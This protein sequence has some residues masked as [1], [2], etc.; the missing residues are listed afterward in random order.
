M[1]ND[2]QH[3][4]EFVRGST[5]RF[6][7]KINEQEILAPLVPSVKSCLEHKNSYVRKYALLVLLHIFRTHFHLVPDAGAL[8]CK[9]LEKE[10]DPVCRKNAFSALT[11]I[12][13]DKARMFFAAWKDDLLSFDANLQLALLDFIRKDAK[14]SHGEK[15]KHVK[16]VLALFDAKSSA[17]RFNAVDVLCA[18][19]TSASAIKLSIVCLA[20]LATKEADLNVKLVVLDKIHEISENC[21]SACADSAL[22][23]LKILACSEIEIK[24]KALVL[25][26]SFVSNKHLDDVVSFL[27]KDFVKIIRG[28]AADSDMLNSY[29][30][31]LLD[32]LNFCLKN[33]A[34]FLTKIFPIFIGVLANEAAEGVTFSNEVIL[35]TV[36]ILRDVL[37]K[38]TSLKGEIFK[39]II[40]SLSKLPYDAFKECIWILGEFSVTADEIQKSFSVIKSLIGEVPLIPAEQ[41]YLESLSQDPAIE[42]DLAVAA[43]I[44]PK[45]ASDGSYANEPN[46]VSV[47]Q[48]SS[49]K[50]K[51]PLIREFL[52]DGKFCIAAAISNLLIKFYLRS[53][54]VLSS[55]EIAK[56]KGEYAL[57]M[58]SMARFGLS[59]LCPQKIDTESYNRILFD[60][61][62]ICQNKA[63]ENVRN[64]LLN[65]D[66]KP[67][68][69]CSISSIANMKKVAKKTTSDRQSVDSAINF[70]LF[71]SLSDQKSAVIDPSEIKDEREVSV[72]NAIKDSK[73]SSSDLRSNL[74]KVTQ[75]TGYS[76]PVYAEA[77]VNFSQYDI[78]MDVLLVNQTNETIQNLTFELTTVGDLKLNSK[79]P[80][81]NLAPYGFQSL[82]VSL[83]I[84]STDN[85]VIH[86]NIVYDQKGKSDCGII[87]LSDVRIDVV[88]Y[89]Q[90][91]HCSMDEFRKMYLKFEWENKISI[92]AFAPDI[93]TFMEFLL[94]KSK[95]ACLTPLDKVK[96]ENSFFSACLYSKTV[97]GEDVVANISLEI[98]PKKAITGHLRLRS[99][100][101]GIAYSLG[102]KISSLENVSLLTA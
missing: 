14:L 98:S 90:P 29:A 12:E 73:V 40:S 16:S 56:A 57:F 63:H 13:F 8:I 5:L 31:F 24:K 99:K 28:S 32:S 60:I 6:L 72:Q 80:T 43:S 67:V 95:F 68:T 42:T 81:I 85:A 30:L 92:K 62:L 93:K 87:A 36:F 96:L 91:A 3:S 101:T 34:D 84:S 17:V 35:K 18:L 88:D 50:K 74:S 48:R 25:L 20:D 19:T 78:I 102:E 47:Q 53:Q 39:T 33:N 83:K 49:K 7:L 86:G 66:I 2:L 44:K 76:D 38:D 54:P 22:E 64:A 23:I 61:Q 75:F 69:K 15:A 4:N 27:N 21:P 58:V 70:R 51:R 97:F 89:I 45:L 46:S 11:F 94:K 37:L 1:R 55:Q 59:A 71:K 77:Y 65:V 9:L 10:Q 26:L 79:P 100:A 52:V 82:T 41:K